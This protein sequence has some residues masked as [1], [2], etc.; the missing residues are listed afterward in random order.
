MVSI[1][2]AGVCAIGPWGDAAASLEETDA[3]SGT[4]FPNT[5]SRT[6]STK[7]DPARINC[8]FFTKNQ[9]PVKV[10]GMIAYASSPGPLSGL[11]SFSFFTS[12]TNSLAG[13][14]AGM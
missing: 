6:A 13:L 11:G 3:F 1:E 5:K 8:G 2:A 12:A 10:T 9:F 14:K 7:P 4:N